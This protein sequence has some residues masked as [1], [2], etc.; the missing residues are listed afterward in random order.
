MHIAFVEDDPDQAEVLKLW[1][2]S[3]G[4]AVDAFANGRDFMEA[5]ARKTYELLL[6]DWVLPD[7]DGGKVIEWIR[8]TVGWEVP[9]LVT[10]VRDAE[11][12]IV[13]G[14]RVGADDYLVKPLKSLELL[15]RIETVAR[16]VKARRQTVL[17]AGDYEIDTERRQCRLTGNAVE[18]TQKELDLAYYLF[19]NPGKLFSRNHLL[20][21]IWGINAAIDTRTVDTHVS[22]LRRKLKLNGEHGW[23]LVPV[24]GYGYRL[25]SPDSA[26][27]K[28]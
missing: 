28:S 4:H 26:P 22:R 23:Q 11:E 24:Y 5:A 1:L 2:E 9:I 10:T 27:A 14:L 18:M 12:E 3:A 16:R 15:A 17:H 19:A 8:S 7:Y 20:D 6:V 13:A 25:E 21:K